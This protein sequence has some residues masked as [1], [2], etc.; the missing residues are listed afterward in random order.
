MSVAEAMLRGRTAGCERT[1]QWDGP[2]GGGLGAR[3][4]SWPF[5][6]GSPR[7][8]LRRQRDKIRRQGSPFLPHGT[9][10]WLLGC[11]SA[12]PFL[13]VSSSCFQPCKKSILFALAAFLI[14]FLP[15]SKQALGEHHRSMTACLQGEGPWAWGGEDCS[16]GR[17]S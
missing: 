15:V 9:R 2:T 12:A 11:G 5:S 1:S 4:Q 3:G 7:L 16:G 14:F 17:H 10:A 13:L 6:Y 8:G